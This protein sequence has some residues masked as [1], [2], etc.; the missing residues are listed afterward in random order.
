M[1][2]SYD[3]ANPLLE[4]YLRKIR[5]YPHPGTCMWLSTAAFFMIAKSG[6]KNPN[7]LS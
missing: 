2:L 1:N 7:V 6:E 3:P 5:A 4:M